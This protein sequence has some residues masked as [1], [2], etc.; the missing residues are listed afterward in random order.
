MP[1]NFTQLFDMRLFS[2]S[3]RQLKNI[4]DVYKQLNIVYEPLKIIKP[5]FKI[6]LPSLQLSVGLRLS[7]PECSCHALAFILSSLDLLSHHQWAQST[8]PGIVWSGWRFQFPADPNG[9]HH[10]Q[11]PAAECIGRPEG[12]S[13]SQGIAQIHPRMWSNCWPF[14]RRGGVPI[15]AGSLSAHTGHRRSQIG[16]LPSIWVKALDI[17]A[18]PKLCLRHQSTDG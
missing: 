3:N 14:Q 12:A 17:K 2:F 13:K 6:P 11:I 9:H 8:R 18:L 10:R 5:M 16:K 4:I 15:G 7:L 1:E